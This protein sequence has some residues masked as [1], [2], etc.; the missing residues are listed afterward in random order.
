LYM[1]VFVTVRTGER[2]GEK[3]VSQK[4]TFKNMPV[5]YI[6]TTGA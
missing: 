2:K 6:L 5:M 3:H 1:I 4:F